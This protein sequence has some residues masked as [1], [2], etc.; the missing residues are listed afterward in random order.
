MSILVGKMSILST[1][2]WVVM[3]IYI[4]IYTHM[5]VYIYIYIYNMCER[6]RPS[7]GDNWHS[8]WNVF[9]VY[10]QNMFM[11]SIIVCYYVLWY[12]IWSCASCAAPME[13]QTA[14]IMLHNHFSAFE[15][16]VVFCLSA[17]TCATPRAHLCGGP[18]TPQATQGVRRTLKQKSFETWR[19]GETTRRQ[20]LGFGI[21]G[22]GFRTWGF[23][24]RATF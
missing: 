8:V 23:G 5:N 4:Y 2:T 18:V 17:T 22:L 20:G 12:V 19:R 3:Y 24:K 13:E 10:I 9:A 16:G 6:V 15:Y 7:V 11:Y 14:L 21:S 1:Y